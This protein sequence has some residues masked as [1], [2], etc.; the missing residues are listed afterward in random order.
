ML[1]AVNN[2]S[3]W[4]MKSY[5]FL[6]Q[7]RKLQSGYYFFFA[8]FSDQTSIPHLQKTH[9]HMSPFS[10][11]W[12]TQTSGLLIC[13]WGIWLP[14][15]SFHEVLHF[16]LLHSIQ[17]SPSLPNENQNILAYLPRLQCFCL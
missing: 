11:V 6:E 9:I 8:A 5:Y 16:A 15:P 1:P 4:Q 17:T 2:V 14:N 10:M 13:S 3:E 7:A 12:N